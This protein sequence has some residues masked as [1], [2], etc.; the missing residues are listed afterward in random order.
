MTYLIGASAAIFYL[1]TTGL[2]GTVGSAATGTLGSWHYFLTQTHVLVRYVRLIFLPTGL[3]LDYD[4]RPSFSLLEP[5]VLA[6]IL[7]LASLL[8][9][10]WRLRRSAPVF[11]FS[12]LWFFITLSP[13]SSVVS[14]VDLIFEHRLYLPMVGV[15]MSFPLLVSLICRK[16]RRLPSFAESWNP[17]PALSQRERGIWV[18]SSII[19]FLLLIGTVLRNELWGDEVRLFADVVAKSPHK[20]RPYNQLAWAHYKR[21]EYDHAFDKLPDK[22]A[23]LSDTLGNLLLKAGQYE[24]AIDLFQKTTQSFKGESLAMTYN[25][26]GV[27][28]LYVWTDLQNRRNQMP[29]EEFASRREQILRPAAEAFSKAVEIEPDLWPALDSYINAMSYMGRGH[30]IESIATER[31]KRQQTVDI[32]ELK[33]QE[34][35]ELFSAFYSIGKVA[36]NNGNYQRADAYFEEAEKLRGDVRIAF[37]NHGY[38]LSVLDQNDRAI[39]KYIKAIRVDPIFI[40]A[41]HNLG[42][43]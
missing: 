12:I 22:T 13:T 17:H 9:L 5:A 28:Y 4:F 1:L 24:K 26:L 33:P 39:D 16:V 20:E 41:H 36:F 37:F 34:K 19:L 15:A 42:L 30:E 6:S 25:N 8:L 43:I 29:A 2:K 35:L 21:G 23:E 31:L 27:A 11:A 18:C 32:K 14:I 3:N 40:E 10:G 38:A 7:F